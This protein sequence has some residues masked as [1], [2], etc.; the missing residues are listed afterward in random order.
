MDDMLSAC[1]IATL[2]L[3]SSCQ[4]LPASASWR[5]RSAIDE[6]VVS[7]GCHLCLGSE[8]RMP[9]GLPM[10]TE[11]ECQSSDQSGSCAVRLPESVDHRCPE[12]GVPACRVPTEGNPPF[13]E[14]STSCNRTRA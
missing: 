4:A 14:P 13:F 2:T 1:E 3:R 9:P 11:G 8:S 7:L 12:T 6:F 5:G 10:G